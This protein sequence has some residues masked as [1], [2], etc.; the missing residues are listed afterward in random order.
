MA[1][2]SGI[3]PGDGDMQAGEKL[4]GYRSVRGGFRLAAVVAAVSMALGPVAASAADPATAAP[5]A[6]DTSDQSS[7]TLPDIVVTAQ[8]HESLLK[9]TPVSVEAFTADRLDSQGIRGVDDLTRL[10]PGV[11][12]Q[13]NGVTATGNYNDENSDIAIRGIDSSAGASTTGI[14]IDDTPI[15]TRHLSFGTLNAFPALFDLDRVEILRGPQGTLFGSGAEGGAVRF[16]QPEPSLTTKSEYFRTELATTKNGAISYEAGAAVGLPLVTDKIGLRVSASYREDG[17]YVNRV[18][19]IDTNPAN[20][21]LSNLQTTG[22]VASNVN[23]QE[24]TT[25]RAALKIA[26]T[27]DTT[28]TPSVYYQRLRLNDTGAFWEN[29]SNLDSGTFVSGNARPNTS[30][31]PFSLWAV[32]VES[33]LGWAELTSN[34][35]Y[36]TRN[37]SSVSDYTQFMGTLLLLDPTVTASG[38]TSTATFTDVQYNVVEESKLQSNDA[39]ARLNWVAGL[40]LSHQH[41]N[42]TEDILAPASETSYLSGVPMPAGNVDHQDPYSAID[43]QY[44]IFGQADYKLT[45]TVKLTLGLRIAS[46]NTAGQ[47]YEAGS[48]IGAAPV[49]AAGSFTEHPVT[50][51]FGVSWQPDA[52]DLFYATAAKG[53]RP[54]GI[55]SGLGQLCAANLTFLGLNS[56]PATYKSDSLWSYEV[57]AKNTL[58]DHRLQIDSSAYF[59][60]WKDIQQNVYLGGCGLQFAANLGKATSKGLDISVNVKATANLLISAEAGYTDARYTRTVYAGVA[61]I[62][63][64]IVNQGDLLAPTPWNLNLSGEYHFPG[65]DVVSP[66]LRADYQ[67]T[68]GQRGTLP[69]QDVSAGGDAAIPNA[70]ATRNLSM[71]AGA[72]WDAW[73]ISGYVNNLLGAQPL[74]VRSHDVFASPLFFD[75]TWRPRTIGVTG[76]YR[77]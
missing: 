27:G 68:A 28:I 32:K 8:R 40:F 31:D 50:P 61:G 51:K 36:F 48:F 7:T 52:N 14:Y 77:F 2:E 75:R 73:D 3:T 15:Q 57:G 42:T 60:D 44:A 12:F 26:V 67:F 10:T 63:A 5:A 19:V 76:T 64:P 33:N 66:Y 22:T 39:N 13:R 17:G 24:T 47:E 56:A 25:F 6:K 38:G 37:Q 35:S 18:G 53:Y 71:R 16:L 45:D 30:V 1:V 55:N 11:T 62:G 46:M 23:S 69:S 41:E 59:I 74:L 20:F 70:P 21:Q 49:A 4:A 9:D 29:L 54:G 65:F 43:K 72:R 58:W 34:T